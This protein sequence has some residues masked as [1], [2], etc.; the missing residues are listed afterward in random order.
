MQFIMRRIGMVNFPLST[1]IKEKAVAQVT[2]CNLKQD[3]F[4]KEVAVINKLATKK[5]VVATPEL[6]KYIQEQLKH[7]KECATTIGNQLYRGV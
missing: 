6:K 4:L 5:P 1:E 3:A 2:A 7:N